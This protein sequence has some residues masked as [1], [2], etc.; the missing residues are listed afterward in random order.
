MIPRRD[1]DVSLETETTPRLQSYETEMLEFR[2]RD[3]TETRRSKQHLE[4]FGRDVGAV[5]VQLQL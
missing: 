3:E 2:Y 5:T 4:T 1:R